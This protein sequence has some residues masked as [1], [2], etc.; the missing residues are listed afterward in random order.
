[1]RM[2]VPFQERRTSQIKALDAVSQ[3]CAG[4]FD[5]ALK[6]PKFLEQVHASGAE[7][8]SDTSPAAFRSFIAKEVTLWGDA[9]KA[10]GVWLSMSSS[11]TATPLTKTGAT[12]SDLVSREHAR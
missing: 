2:L 1:M 9:V 7:A 12:I 6:E 4:E 11:P 8:S 3:F 10:A 5:R